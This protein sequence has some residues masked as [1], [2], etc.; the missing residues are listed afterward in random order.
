[1][2]TKKKRVN[3]KSYPAARK[4]AL[5]EDASVGA[6][7]KTIARVF[8]LPKQSVRL[9]LPSGRAARSDKRIGR[10]LREWGW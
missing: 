8:G 5:R 9:V 4:F 6:G 10:L 1:M 2:K 3:K 7:E